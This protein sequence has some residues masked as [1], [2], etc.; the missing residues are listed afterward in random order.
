M[1]SPSQSLP[2]MER[3]RE[4]SPRLKARIAGVFDL[5]IVVVGRLAG[6]ARGLFVIGDA[7]AFERATGRFFDLVKENLK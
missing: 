1:T 2:M 5:L 4:V 3:M 7:A 6:Y